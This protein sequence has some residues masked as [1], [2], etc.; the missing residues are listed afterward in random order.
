MALTRVSELLG[1]TLTTHESPQIYTVTV[2]AKTSAH[3]QYQNGSDNGFK[4]DGVE[5]PFLHLVPG[6]TYKFDQSDSTNSGHPLVFYYEENKTT[7]YTTNVTNN[8]TPGQAG[9]YT[10]IVVGEAT[11]ALLYYQCSAHEYMG[12]GMEVSTHNMTN[13]DT[14]DLTEGSINQYYTSARFNTDFATKDT[15]DIS[16]GTTNLYHTANR[17]RLAISASGSL[18]YDSATG[19]MSYT[20]RTDSEINTLIDNRITG[21]DAVAN[22]VEQTVDAAFIN[23]LSID[24][25]TLGGDTPAYYL[26]YNNF[27]NRPS[28]ILNFGISDG[29]S[30]QVLQTDG[31][32]NFS[33]TNLP[34]VGS[35]NTAGYTGYEDYYYNVS[36]DQT[37]FGT[38][39]S[40]H[41]KVQVFLNGVLL[42]DSDFSFTE[43]TGV[44]TLTSNAVSGDEVT[45]WGFNTTDLLNHELIT[46]ANTGEVTIDGFVQI[47]DYRE[48]GSKAVNLSTT[49]PTNLGLVSSNDFLGAKLL[50][51][52]YNNSSNES[53][54]TEAL[55]LTDNNGSNP[56]ITTYGTMY[57]NNTVGALA[58]F[59][60]VISSNTLSLEVTCTST[61]STTIR[62]AYTAI[63]T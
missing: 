37:T 2:A 44:V 28:S 56:L 21:G 6:T 3:P 62:V 26:N 16:E 12:W 19:V 24:A 31:L 18:S 53:Q 52:V 20:E 23:A 54:I 32:G 41:D 39:A 29:A 13:F 17:A 33:F 25:D 49:T 15:D 35:G 42:D 8:G 27:T 50:I 38:T 59:D 47:G 57:S 43:S 40:T 14:D 45:I 58:S 10:Q 61:D 7:S 30:G 9:A 60:A 4:L 22:V 11:P 46:V 55:I 34:G 36:A 51:S 1:Q 63:N 48:E 5:A